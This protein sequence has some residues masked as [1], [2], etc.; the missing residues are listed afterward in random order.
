M[1]VRICT[2]LLITCPSIKGYLEV[3]RLEAKGQQKWIHI[4]SLKNVDKD[5]RNVETHYSRECHS[6][7]LH[8]M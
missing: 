7:E 2:N 5:F 8:I 6:S 1:Y 3:K 4:L